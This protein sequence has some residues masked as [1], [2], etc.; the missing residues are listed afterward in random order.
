MSIAAQPLESVPAP[1][2]P[3]GS[4]GAFS[5]RDWLLMIGI[6]AISI[7]VRVAF[8]TGFFGSDEVTYVQAA[9]DAAAGLWSNP[10]YIGAI[11]LG[12]NYAMAAAIVV[13]GSS[14]AAVASWSLLC[15]VLEIGVVYWFAKHAFGR[16]VAV[17]AALVLS[18]SPLHVHLA[19]RIMADSPVAL[20]ITLT[21]ALL[22]EAERRG[23]RALFIGAGLA[24]GFV[25]WIK[26]A[27]EIFILIPLASAALGRRNL[28]SY[29]AFGLAATAVVVA[30]FAAM[31]MLT[32]NPLH[33]LD[34]V[35]A[36]VTRYAGLAQ[37]NPVVNDDK[38]TLFYLRYLFVTPYHTWILGYLAAFGAIVAGISMRRGRSDARALKFLLVWGVGLIAVFSLFPVELVPLRLI[39]KQ[40]NYMTIFLAPLAV[41]GAVGVESIRNKATKTFLLAAYVL[42][43]VVLCAF[44]QETIRTF[45]ANSAE[46]LRFAARHPTATI[47]VTR[48]AERLNTWATLV[49]D[50]GVTPVGNVRALAGLFEQ[51]RAPAEPVAAGDA[52]AVVDMQTLDWGR[53]GLT[54]ARDVP[55]CW[56]N[57]GLLEPVVEPTTGRAIVG[58]TVRLL[59]LVPVPVGRA[60]AQRVESRFTPAKA[61][62]YRIPPTCGGRTD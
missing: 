3:R 41:L 7:V 32:G 54:T 51:G 16:A 57:A 53:N 18:L 56:M 15:S 55:T 27:A 33:L 24:A 43:A 46:T 34:S 35:R 12:M 1:G 62:V 14:E 37:A 17:V 45:T 22:F 61:V 58:A 50:T 52:F 49:P 8:Y 9:R 4:V 20:F 5:S 11:R 59:R 36:S 48:N 28:R 29:W 19:G 25:F 31:W 23:E 44:E 47:Y 42:G 39:P 40:A 10:S 13:F 21:F 6:A 30:N 26:E 38:A 60:L 2:V